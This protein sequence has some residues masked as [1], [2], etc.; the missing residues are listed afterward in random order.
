MEL[1]VK[2]TEEQD[3][4]Q[5]HY[6]TEYPSDLFMISRY[7]FAS[8]FLSQQ[9]GPMQQVPCLPLVAFAPSALSP[10]SHHPAISK[11]SPNG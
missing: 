2:K 6:C 1:Q 10:T 5:Q 8:Y 3:L 7:A 11:S 4:P 9:N